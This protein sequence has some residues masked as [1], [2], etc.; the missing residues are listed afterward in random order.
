MTTMRAFPAKD[1]STWVAFPEG[2]VEALDDPDA[3]DSDPV[4][5]VLRR[6]TITAPRTVVTD[7][8]E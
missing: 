5:R 2:I 1:G 7:D 3:A 4:R 6:Q 8:S